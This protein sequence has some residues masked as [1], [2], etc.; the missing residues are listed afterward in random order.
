M[1]SILVILITAAF[2]YLPVSVFTANAVPGGNDNINFSLMN[3]S[4]KSIPLI[5]P[6][7]MRPNLSPFSKSGV[8]LD[9]GQKIFFKYKG[10][11][12][13]LLIVDSSYEGKKV[14]VAKLIKDRIATLEKENK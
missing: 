11:R 10:K 13:L 12:Q 4:S 6:G 1:K 9:P 8:S 14:K 3:N 5:I 7:T 2:S